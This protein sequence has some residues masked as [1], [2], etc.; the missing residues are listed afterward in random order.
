[1]SRVAHWFRRAEPAALTAVSQS[2]VPPASAIEQVGDDEAIGRV[3]D[4]A[5]ALV[6]LVGVHAHDTDAR[7][8]AEARREADQWRRHLTTG[9]GRPG[10]GTGG[11]QHAGGLAARDW[12]GAVRY[13]TA[14]RQAEHTYVARTL[15]EL[16]ST[17]WTLVQ[18]LHDVI[19]AE[20]QAGRSSASAVRQL[21][22]LVE[23][24]EPEALRAA[25]RAAVGE[26]GTLLARREQERERQLADLGREVA[27]LGAALEEARR[28]GSTDPLTGLGNRRAFD[29]ADAHAAALHG[30]WGQSACV[31][32]AGVDLLKQLNDTAGDAA[33]DAA[34]ERVAAQLS[35]SFL[36]RTDVVARIGGDEFAVLVRDA[37]LE[38][39]GRLGA[40]LVAGMR[41]S[42]RPA[43]EP[44]QAAE[45]REL[46]EIGLSV[47]VAAP[48]PASRPPRGSR[49]PTP[50]C[51]SRS[52]RAA[53][54]SPRR[55]D[56]PAAQGRPSTSRTFMTAACSRGRARGRR[57]RRLGARERRMPGRAGGVRGRRSGMERHAA[58]TRPPRTP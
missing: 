52:A 21:R 19:G 58:G 23:E 5:G 29:A 48:S 27:S 54:R 7:S 25:A 47:G 34:L 37:A 24:S 3:L 1:M 35:R 10:R 9:I 4:A 32:L 55:P 13:A 49:G 22:T 14:D 15:E 11:A 39:G 38:E 2:S 20:A 41:A 56:A 45:S 16:R 53:A 57:R 51:T 36:R 12:E 33:G 42:A 31:L 8:A 28:E 30:L 17:V 43:G 18:G 6:R 46:L 50:R 26:L 40:R 44:R